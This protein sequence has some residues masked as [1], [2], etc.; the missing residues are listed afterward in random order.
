MNWTCLRSPKANS[1]LSYGPPRR[2]PIMYTHTP[3]YQ[4]TKIH[5]TRASIQN[6]KYLKLESHLRQSPGLR[7]TASSLLSPSSLMEDQKN[8]ASRRPP[9]SGIFLP[10]VRWIFIF[11]GIFL[12][13][14][15]VI[16][17]VLRNSI[18][19]RPLPDPLSFG[20]R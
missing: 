17:F 14:S 1:K 7:C 5:D 13:V 16:R 2:I 15:I 6:Y 12:V 19:L 20:G 18:I 11:L 4:H 3:K 10:S 9:K 8:P